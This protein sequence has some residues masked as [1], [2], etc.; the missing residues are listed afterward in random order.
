MSQIFIMFFEFFKTGLFAVGG[1]LATLPFLYEIAEKYDWFDKNIISDMIAIS[2]STPGPIGINMATYSG[3]TCFGLPG[4]LLSTTGLVL[5]SVIVIIIVANFLN[6]F[7]ENKLVQSG[8]Y[9]LRPAV[10][11][12]IAVAALEVFKESVINIEAFLADMNI[13]S[14]FCIPAC[15]LFLILFFVNRKWKPHPLIII[16]IAAIV[17]IIFKF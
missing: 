1:G 4:A 15:I 5:P 17:G 3:F 10:T 16:L 13:L 12:L 14:L 8:F 11:G 7:K 9:G 2:E 6:K